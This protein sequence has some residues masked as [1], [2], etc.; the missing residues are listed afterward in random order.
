DVFLFRPRDIHA[1]G[2]LRDQLDELGDLGLREQADLNVELG[3]AVG[4]GGHAVLGDE[5]EGRKED[6]LYRGDHREDDEG[7][8]PLADARNPAEIGDDPEAVDERVRVKEAH[9]S[10]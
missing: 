10:G 3:A 6:R 7:R 8:V 4:G 5:D 2:D 1:L 9:A